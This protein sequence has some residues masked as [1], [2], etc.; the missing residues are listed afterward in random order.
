MSKTYKQRAYRQGDVLIFEVPPEHIK[1]Y[2]T[3]VRH[4]GEDIILALGEVT[5]HRHRI[6]SAYVTEYKDGRRRLLDV[7]KQSK[8]LHEEHNPIPLPPGTYEVK[9]ERQYGIGGE[10]RAVYD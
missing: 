6:S 5:G 9:I 8:V 10:V 4:N 3:K 1:N 2:S 7:H